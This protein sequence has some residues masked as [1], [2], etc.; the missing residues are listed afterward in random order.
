MMMSQWHDFLIMVGGAAAA[1]TGLV[2]VA[3]SLNLEVIARDATHRHRA[4]GTLTGFTAAF[5]ICALALMGDQNEQ[6]AGVEW[7]VISGVAAGI[8]IHGYVQ[9]IKIGKSSIGLSNNRLAVGTSLY[10]IEII[11]AVM[12][13]LG[14]ISGLYIASVALIALIVFTITGAWLLVIGVYE[15]RTRQK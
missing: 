2:F 15:A 11:G 7:L 9:A 3:M 6:A 13:A 8:Y 10:I 12:L 5:M 4:I 14:H 1:L